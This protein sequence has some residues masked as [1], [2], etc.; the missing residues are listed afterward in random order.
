MANPT[1]RVAFTRQAAV[2][3]SDAVRTVEAGN[4]G[5]AGLSF[6][7]VMP[8]SATAN[9]FRVCTFTGT[10]AI[11]ASKTVT[12][13]TEE[14]T[15]TVSAVNLFFPLSSEGSRTGAVARDG[16]AWYLVDVPFT[17]ATVAI[18]QSVSQ[19]NVVTDVQIS[20]VL[21]T[22]NCLITVSRTNTTASIV[23]VTSTATASIVRF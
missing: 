6:G 15:A 7:R 18:V 1:E 20:A 19:Q 8:S 12:V 14:N 13:G 22:N 10:W 16:T 23:V 3:I 5:A 17:T 2:R 9:A 4:R 11:G 21:N